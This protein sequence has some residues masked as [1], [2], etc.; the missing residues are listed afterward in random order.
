M[1]GIVMKFLFVLV[2]FC[3]VNVA[4]AQWAYSTSYN[5]LDPANDASLSADLY[6]NSVSKY[7]F[8]TG[9]ERGIAYRPGSPDIVYIGRGNNTSDNRGNAGAFCAIKLTPY[10][11]SNYTDTGLLTSGGS[12]AAFSFVQAIFYEPVLDKVWVIDGASATARVW[13]FDG[14]AVGGSPNGGGIS[15]TAT[16]TNIV[17]PFVASGLAGGTGRGISVRAVGATTTTGTVTVALGMGNHLEVWESTAGLTGT[18]TMKFQS[19]TDPD[20][21]GAY[22]AF[23]TSAV[24]DVAFD[25]NGDIWIANGGSGSRLIHRYALSSSGT[26]VIATESCVLP[27]GAFDNS[28]AGAS[29]NSLI[30]YKDGSRIFALASLR[31]G[32][33]NESV[34][35]FRRNGSAGAYTFTALDGF[36]QSI[37]NTGNAYCDA[38]LATVRYKSSTLSPSI[39]TYPVGSTNAL[40]YFSLPLSSS[41]NLTLTNRKLYVNAFLK[42]T[43]SVPVSGVQAALLPPYITF[44][45]TVDGSTLIPGSTNNALLGFSASTDRSTSTLSSVGI[46]RTSGSTSVDADVDAV[47]VWEDVN[48]NNTIDPG[49]DTQLGSGV[50]SSGSVTITLTGATVST[51][52]KKFLIGVDV[53]S[54]A[55]T[56]GTLGL[57]ISAPSSITTAAAADVA[58]AGLPVQNGSNAALPVELSAFTASV[59]HGSVLLKWITETEVANAGFRIERKMQNTDWTQIGFV[60]GNGTTNSRSF[61]DFTDA[62]AYGSVQYRLQQI[63]RDGKTEYS[64]IVEASVRMTAAD[65]ALQQNF[66]NP[67]NPST[68]I[69]FMVERSEFVKVAVYNSI[70]QE[71][72]TLFNGV[73]AANQPYSVTL[74]GRSLSSGTYFYALHSSSRHEVRKMTVL[75]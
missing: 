61:Y 73:A 74:D 38:K 57:K 30:M 14:G 28:G 48:S 4:E 69:S 60:K 25:E 8:T 15:N 1:K 75:K 44:A 6:N 45:K 29:V 19:S 12:P 41:G 59:Q 21:A 33:S 24:R 40:M 3:M 67:F 66:P 17:T 16:A 47:K 50:L 36:G 18:Y 72:T 63:D 62:S 70:G 22:A 11:A 56:S 37:T 55:S 51:T 26:G 9:Q 52:T 2:L 53:N 27:S 71:V 64:R 31:S 39:V 68:T 32:V 46:A 42:D 54:G 20:G 5:V 7:S 43:Q 13:Y 49:T 58:E 23:T 65:F 10:G 34:V 35:R